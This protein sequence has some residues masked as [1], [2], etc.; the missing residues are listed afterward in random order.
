MEGLTLILD[1]VAAV[2]HK[3]VPPP[4]ALK[5]VLPPAHIVTSIPA[6]AVGN[7]VIVTT[8]ASVAL[9]PLFVTVTV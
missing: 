5:V 3:Y 1:V 6:F 8:T 9:Q 2:F 4:V 7:G